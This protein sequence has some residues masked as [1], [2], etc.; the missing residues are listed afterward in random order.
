MRSNLKRWKTLAEPISDTIADIVPYGLFASG[1]GEA[2][3]VAPEGRDLFVRRGDQRHR[4][5][6]IGRKDS[7]VAG[8][9]D[10]ECRLFDRGAVSSSAAREE[11]P[12]HVESQLS[13]VH[14]RAK[15]TE[16]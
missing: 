8:I 7:R 14:S 15:P 11:M 13:G 9:V 6:D 1:H 12:D 16:P 10:D 2:V 4:A 5:L 3:M